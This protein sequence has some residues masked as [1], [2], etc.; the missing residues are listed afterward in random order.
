MKYLKL[1]LMKIVNGNKERSV[2][3]NC[4][5]KS[6]FENTVRHPQKMDVNVRYFGPIELTWKREN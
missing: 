5:R 1:F 2:L 6:K 4:I 3:S